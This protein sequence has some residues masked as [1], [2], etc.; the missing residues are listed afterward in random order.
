[1]SNAPKFST[2]TAS[3][4]NSCTGCNVVRVA[5]PCDTI[6]HS[7]FTD[8]MSRRLPAGS[9]LVPCRR[10]LWRRADQKGTWGDW[11][12]SACLV[13]R[14]RRAAN[15]VGRGSLAVRHTAYMHQVSCPHKSAWRDKSRRG[16]L[17]YAHLLS[18]NFVTYCPSTLDTSLIG[19]SHSPWTQRGTYVR[20]R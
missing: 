15:N 1:M 8:G 10:C 9:S 5:M 17:D 7:R 18:P 19:V 14:G 11:L 16:R 3:A 4:A 13:R 12:Y 2:Y 6:G 20:H